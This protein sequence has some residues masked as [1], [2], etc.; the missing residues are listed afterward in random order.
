MYECT[1]IFLKYCH[2]PFSEHY[3]VTSYISIKQITMHMISIDK[4]K[5]KKKEDHMHVHVVCLL[6]NQYHR[7][8]NIF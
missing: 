6:S 7:I 4:R 3:I 5:K 2:T 1:N 8:I